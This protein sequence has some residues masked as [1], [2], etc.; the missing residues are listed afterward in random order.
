VH[1]EREVPRVQV[2]TEESLDGTPLDRIV[3][4][5]TFDKFGRQIR[6]V[7]SRDLDGDGDLDAADNI[8][9]FTQEYDNKDRT[10][11]FADRLTDGID[12]LLFSWTT[13]TVYGKNTKTDTDDIDDD[14]VGTIDRRVVTV[15]PL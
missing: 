3:E 6:S 7:E 15:I 10:V 11:F 12:T 13:T 14:G 4:I 5:N 8:E 1:A 2:V 9:T